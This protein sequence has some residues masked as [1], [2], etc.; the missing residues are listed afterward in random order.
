M[1]CD[2]LRSLVL[3]IDNFPSLQEAFAY[4]QNEESRRSTV[5]SPVKINVLLI[6]MMIVVYYNYKDSYYIGVCLGVGGE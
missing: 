4:V 1:E 2:L 6:D 5:M 3:S